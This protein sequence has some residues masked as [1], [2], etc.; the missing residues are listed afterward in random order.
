MAL[1]PAICV[2][3][4]LLAVAFFCVEGRQHVSPWI[5]L[6]SIVVGVM[7][8]TILAV[9]LWILDYGSVVFP[10]AGFQ[11][12]RVY[13]GWDTLYIPAS[14]SMGAL[15]AV[16]VCHRKHG[17]RVEPN[18]AAAGDGHHGAVG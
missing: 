4:P 3:L 13:Y 14:A 9:A 1:G 17:G 10:T 15:A 8:G 7:V 6:L 2:L 16:F 18:K 11:I 12:G 5:R